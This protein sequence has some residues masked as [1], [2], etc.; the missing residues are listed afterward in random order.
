VRRVYEFECV[1]TVTYVTHCV[2]HKGRGSVFSCSRAKALNALASRICAASLKYSMTMTRFLQL[3]ATP[4]FLVLAV[5]TELQPVS[6]CT[7]VTPLLKSM[8]VMYALMAVF[9]VTPWFH[10]Q[11][12][13]G[14]GCNT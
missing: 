1:H 13:A 11:C 2:G 12:R 10:T 7:A 9:H 4:T 14:C 5:Y 8:T 3:A 6:I